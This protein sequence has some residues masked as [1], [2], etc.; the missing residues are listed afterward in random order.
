MNSVYD[1]G[2]RFAIG[3]MRIPA[4]PASTVAIT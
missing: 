3:A 2:S 1:V 4:T